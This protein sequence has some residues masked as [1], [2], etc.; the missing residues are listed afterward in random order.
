MDL[1]RRQVTRGQDE[2][3]LTPK[4]FDLLVLLI[5][6]APRVVPKSEL[7]ERLWPGSFVSDATLVGLVKELRRALGDQDPQAPIIRT[8]HR[9]GYAFCPQ[10]Q[11][12][13]RSSPGLSHWLVVHERRVPLE[14]GETFIGRDPSSGVCL[15]FPGVSRRHARLLVGES[16]VLLEDLNSK[17]GTRLAETPV[18]GQVLLRDGDRIHIGSV[19]LVYRVSGSGMST[20]TQIRRATPQEPS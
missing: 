15:D 6:D 12:A 13:S 5:S 17:N 11:R 14:K 10:I 2:V 19:L 18:T 1:P 3:H 4:A 16:G 20:E 9:I 7:H 8:A